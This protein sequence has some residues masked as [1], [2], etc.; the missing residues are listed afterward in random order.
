[1]D[2]EITTIVLGP[3]ILLSRWEVLHREKIPEMNDLE[4]LKKK[5]RETS[6]PYAP[7]ILCYLLIAVDREDR[8]F[9]LRDTAC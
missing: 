1:M 4:V 8:N 2:H 5:E 3:F 6:S 7:V 9:S